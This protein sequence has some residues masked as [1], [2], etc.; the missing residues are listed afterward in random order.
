MWRTEPAASRRLFP[1]SRVTHTVADLLAP[2]P[3]ALCPRKLRVAAF[4]ELS[5][6]G[7]GPIQAPSCRFSSASSPLK[8]AADFGVAVT[9]ESKF[10]SVGKALW[11]GVS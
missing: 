5:A 1:F 3:R 11:V 4:P 9:V 6:R 10:T 2:Q 7:L 8:K